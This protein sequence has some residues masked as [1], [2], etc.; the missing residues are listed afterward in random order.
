[1]TDAPHQHSLFAETDGEI[2][3]PAPRGA[4]SRAARSGAHPPPPDPGPPQRLYLT[5]DL[6]AATGLARTAMDFYLRAGVVR[7]SSRTESGYLLFDEDELALLRKVIAW[8][9]RGISLKEIKAYIGRPGTGEE[10]VSG[11]GLAAG[12]PR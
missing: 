6:R 4:A 9:S 10:P 12:T 5:A 8:R 11:S 3:V 1:M 2:D 7:P